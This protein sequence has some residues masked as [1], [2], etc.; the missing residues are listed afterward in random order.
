MATITISDAYALAEEQLRDDFRRATERC[1][2][3]VKAIDQTFQGA[4]LLSGA[5]FQVPEVSS[6]GPWNGF[7]LHVEKSDLKRVH[8]AVGRLR[9]AGKDVADCKKRTICI[10]L[11]ATAYPP[12]IVE[13]ITKLPR[14]AKCKIVTQRQKAYSYKALV[15]D[16]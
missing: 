11:Q 14:S 5:G 2:E 1:D 16:V 15:C 3:R 4:A 13:Y 7:T 9:L 12:I 6:W 8:D 10:R